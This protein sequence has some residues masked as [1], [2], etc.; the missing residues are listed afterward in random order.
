MR[1]LLYQYLLSFHRE[2]HTVDLQD[3]QNPRY[4][5]I[6]VH[7]APEEIFWYSI[8]VDHFHVIPAGQLP[9]HI[10]D[11]GF[12]ESEQSILPGYCFFHI[13]RS[14]LDVCGA[15]PAGLLTWL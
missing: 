10:R 11:G 15:G 2:M 4:I 13:G 6:P 7:L 14:D 12:V 5:D 3:L 1:E 9:H 8:G